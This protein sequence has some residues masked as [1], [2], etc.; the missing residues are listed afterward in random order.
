MQQPQ[1][2]GAIRHFSSSSA[3]SLLGSS[4]RDSYRV[5]GVSERLFKVCAKQANYKITEEQR[6]QDQV[7]KME[8]GEEVGEPIIPDSVWHTSESSVPA[9]TI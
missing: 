5:V 9:D 6:K 2:T 1:A 3:R 7:K 8:D 4:F